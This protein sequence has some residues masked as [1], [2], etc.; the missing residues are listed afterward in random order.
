MAL[1]QSY[2]LF[3]FFVWKRALFGTASN[4]HYYIALDLFSSVKGKKFYRIVKNYEMFE[5]SVNDKF[6][7]NHNFPKLRLLQSRLT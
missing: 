2:V 7:K 1:I 6:N 5:L 3:V 4:R